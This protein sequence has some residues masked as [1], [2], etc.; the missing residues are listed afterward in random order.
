MQT[1]QRI[2]LPPLSI[3]DAY[4]AALAKSPPKTQALLPDA[5]ARDDHFVEVTLGNDAS[6]SSKDQGKEVKVCQ[7]N[8]AGTQAEPW[9][10]GLGPRQFTPFHRPS[11]RPDC[12]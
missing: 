4:H 8:R 12:A 2:T 7:G 9:S 1:E 5:M 11:A 3:V 6:T 10:K